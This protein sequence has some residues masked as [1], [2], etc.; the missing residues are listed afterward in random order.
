MGTLT[1]AL[2][3]SLIFVRILDKDSFT[4][5][6]NPFSSSVFEPEEPP[7]EEPLPEELPPL[8]LVVGSGLSEIFFKSFISA[9]EILTV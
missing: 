2:G 5:A 6:K 9:E 4:E 1:T 7:L 8:G 3:S